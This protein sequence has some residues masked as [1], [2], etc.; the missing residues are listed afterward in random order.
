MSEEEM[1]Q[2]RRWSGWY[3]GM[4]DDDE[5]TLFNRAVK[6]GYAYRSYEGAAALLGLAKIRITQP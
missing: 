3:A 6:E 5:M 1:E 4:L 2:V